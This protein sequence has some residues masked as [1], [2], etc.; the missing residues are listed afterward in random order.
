MEAI[1]HLRINIFSLSLVDWNQETLYYFPVSNTVAFTLF[2]QDEVCLFS[3]ENVIGSGECDHK[4]SLGHLRYQNCVLEE[5]FMSQQLRPQLGI[6]RYLDSTVHS[7]DVYSAIGRSLDLP[8]C[9]PLL[10]LEEDG[11]RVC[12]GSGK[13]GGSGSLDW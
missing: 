3:K 12:G 5:E 7:L 4:A 2:L 13:K 6:Y 11:G 1:V 8:K 10:G 9:I